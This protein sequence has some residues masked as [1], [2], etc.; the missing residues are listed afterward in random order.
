MKLENQVTNLELSKKLKELGVKQE[1]YFK[2][3]IYDKKSEFYIGEKDRLFF[4]LF[5]CK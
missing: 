2:W 5:L 3:C 4:P 1:S